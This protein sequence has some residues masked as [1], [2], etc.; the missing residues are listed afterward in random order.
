MNFLGR[1]TAAD[2]GIWYQC[3]SSTLTHFFAAKFEVICVFRATEG[4]FLYLFV[5]LMHFCVR[6]RE[7]V[8][9]TSSLPVIW[10]SF[11][12]MWK[13]SRLSVRTKGKWTNER[14]ACEIRTQHAY[15]KTPAE[16]EFSPSTRWVSHPQCSMQS[17]IV[18]CPLC[19]WSVQ[20]EFL[21]HFIPDSTFW[22]NT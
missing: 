8:W 16:I 1:Q 6:S 21:P 11:F 19:F 15:L 17:E 20:M 7:F 22:W 13:S 3:S 4:S 18:N 5:L 2:D 12:L 14:C 10:G 9:P